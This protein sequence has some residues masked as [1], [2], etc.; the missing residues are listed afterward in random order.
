[1]ETG[2]MN[3]GDK[4]IIMGPSTGVVEMTVGELRVDLKPVDGVVKGDLF[5]MPTEVRV[6]RNDKLYK[7]CEASTVNDNQG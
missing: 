4:I 3:I 7:I 2:S 1:M 6:R 5:S